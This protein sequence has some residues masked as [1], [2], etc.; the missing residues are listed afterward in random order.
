MHSLTQSRDYLRDRDGYYHRDRDHD[1][2][3]RERYRDARH[4]HRYF[5]R[6]CKFRF[7]LNPKH[8]HFS[9]WIC[10]IL[11]KPIILH[12]FLWPILINAVEIDDPDYDVR[13]EY[14][15]RERE[16]YERERDR[17]LDLERERCVFKARSFFR[18]YTASWIQ[19]NLFFIPSFSR[20]S[21]SL[22]QKMEY[23]HTPMSFE[24]A[25]VMGRTGRTLPSPKLNGYK[26][27][28]FAA[29]SGAAGLSGRHSD[30]DEEDWC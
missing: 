26:P 22:L 15:D 14:R 8:S 19:S 17:D 21:D 10:G 28:G 3:R 29:S 25:L 5:A 1:H 9:A 7:M 30:S 6:S 18:A 24:Q 11:I 12:I 20:F 27:K 4:Q 16:A 23:H 2:D 13:Y